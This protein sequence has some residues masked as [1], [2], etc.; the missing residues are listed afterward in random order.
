M[1]SILFHL[2][3]KVLIGFIVAQFITSVIPILFLTRCC[4]VIFFLIS[5][6]FIYFVL[7]AHLC[8]FIHLFIYAVLPHRRLSSGLVCLRQLRMKIGQLKMKIVYLLHYLVAVT[9]VLSSF[10]PLLQVLYNDFVHCIG[11]L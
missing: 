5:I 8:L 2:L 6:L 1:T 9:T 10:M 11:P 4:L 3:R 7:L